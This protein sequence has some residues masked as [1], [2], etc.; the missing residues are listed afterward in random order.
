MFCTSKYF[1]RDDTKSVDSYD[2]ANIMSAAKASGYGEDEY[3]ILVLANNKSAAKTVFDNARRRF[4]TKP[5]TRGE[6]LG[7]EDLEAAFI[8]LRE[9]IGISET[10]VKFIQTTFLG[11]KPAQPFLALRFHQELIVEKTLEIKKAGKKNTV[12][13]GVVARGGKTY[14]CGGLIRAMN[15]KCVFIVAGAYTETRGQFLEHLLV[16]S[17]N[18]FQDFAEYTV[19][20]VKAQ[21]ETFSF[22]SKKKYIF[23]ISAELLKLT[24]TTA[25]KRDV[26]SGVQKKEIVPDLVF[27]DEIHKG[28]TTQLADNAMA[29]IGESAFKVFMT[30]TYVKPFIKPE[31]NIESD[32]LITWGY[33]DIQMAKTLGSDETMKYFETKYGEELCRRTVSLQRARGTSLADIEG[34]YREFPEIQFLTTM[35][36]RAFEESMAKQNMLD[37]KSGFSMRALLAVTKDCSK[38][39]FKTRYKCLKNP[40]T[41]GLFLN[42]IGP[43]AEQMSTLDGMKV[44]T[45]AS[46]EEHIIN[47]IGRNSQMAGDFL[48]NIHTEFKPHSQL[49]FLPQPISDGSES[50]LISMMTALAS[51]LIKHPWFSKN[52]SI[53]VVASSFKN[54]E[55]FIYDNDRGFV[56]FTNGGDDTKETIL[57]Y[58]R[59]AYKL[60]QGLIIIAGKMLTLGISLPCVNV[61]GLL[62]DS[63]SS[64]LTYQKMFRALTESHGKKLGYVIDVNPLRTLKTLYDY[65]TIEKSETNPSGKEDVDA[66]SLTNLYLVDQDQM[67]VINKDG[68][69]LSSDALHTKINEMLQSSRKV[70][71]SIME[72]AASRLMTITLTDEVSALRSVLNPSKPQALQLALELSG[73]EKPPSGIETL[74]TATATKDKKPD[75]GKQLLQSLREM[76][77]T[78]LV[79]MAFLTTATTFDEALIKY[80]MNSDGIKDTIYR[81]FVDRGLIKENSNQEDI[82][83][84]FEPALMKAK[85][86]VTHP[87]FKMRQKFADTTNDHKEVIEFI[88]QNLKPKREQVASRGEVFTPPN[89]VGDMVSHLPQDVWSNPNLTWL[90]PANGIGNFPVTVFA[91]LDEGLKGVIPDVAARRK[92]IVENMLYMVELDDTNIMLSK[93]LLQ[94]MCGSLDCKFNLVKA[95]FLELNDERLTREFGINRFD[96]IMGNPPYNAGGV[97]KGGGTIWPKFVTRSFELISPNGFITF[98]HPPG[99]RKFYDSKDR[100]N[101]GKIWYTIRNKPWFLRYI[102][103]SDKPRFVS[104]NVITDYYVIQASPPTGE[105]EYSCSSLGIVSKGTAMMNLPFIPNILTPETMSILAKIFSAKGGPI[106]IHYNQSFKPT[107]DDKDATGTPHYHFTQRDGTRVIYNKKYET[108]PDYVNSPKVLMTMKAGYE[109]GRLFAFYENRPIG[110]TNN[111]MYM[112]V[113]SDEFGNKLVGFFNSDIITFLM[114]I[115]QYSEPPNYI[116]EFKI[117]NQ[118]RVPESLNSYDLTSNELQIINTVVHKNKKP[119]EGGKTLRAKK[120]PNTTLRK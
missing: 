3:R 34:V 88:E 42:Y 70:Y 51:L 13:W 116:N 11:E 69:R 98:V 40:S 49:W 8:R 71:K 54:D 73:E 60:N 85:A 20:D 33:A 32:N 93:K 118:L 56:G 103:I 27:F 45:L 68:S 50:P 43:A 52:F 74:T 114:K 81:V 41:V 38:L 7:R 58:E 106:D 55:D 47:R 35:F 36:S 110:T 107:A 6:I 4:M 117:L 21:G 92:H 48:S 39:T 83:K 17:K 18:G 82:N 95:D 78:S 16:T 63:E 96:V 61:V 9:R 112:A 105:T 87:Y 104:T 120:S 108:V 75:D 84:V 80:Q 19:V 26:L 12:L 57:D 14:I 23:F 94:K 46:P 76:I 67:F 77:L 25:K 65:T 22:D 72:E 99:W 102:D 119:A 101:Q 59:R 29:L 24:G 2:I 15:P 91:K 28:G 115:T 113:E 62:D 30:A 44:P 109:R 64:D 1:K 10:P 100:E 37:E 111:S 53:V 86:Q 79:M 66:V 31:Y 90:D 5:V 89:L 97:S